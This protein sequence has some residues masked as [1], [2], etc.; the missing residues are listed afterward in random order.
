MTTDE[1]IASLKAF[2]QS[3]VDIVAVYL[4]GSRARGDAVSHSDTDVAILFY[5]GT[6]TN[7]HDE[8]RF[9]GEIMD[10]L[11]T[12][13]VDAL[14]LNKLP[15]SFQFGI[16][17]TGTLIHVN[18]EKARI[19]WEVNMLGHYYDIRPFH[20]IYDLA[21]LERLKERLTHDQRREYEHTLAALA[22]AN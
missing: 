7:G 12:D 11:N 5:P 22:L 19:E 20:K 13:A 9:A 16:T 8:L 18:D 21:Y 3:R 4:F 14:V 6:L 10:V 1:I 2:A 17:A 15:V